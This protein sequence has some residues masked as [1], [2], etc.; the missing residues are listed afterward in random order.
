MK[1]LKMAE[2]QDLCM[3]YLMQKTTA[4]ALKYITV[5]KRTSTTYVVSFHSIKPVFDKH[6]MVWRSSA[7]DSFYKRHAIYIEFPYNYWMFKEYI[8]SVDEMN[9]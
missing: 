4:Y 5:H 6:S 2:M 3:K 7:Y 8:F 9:D 1:F